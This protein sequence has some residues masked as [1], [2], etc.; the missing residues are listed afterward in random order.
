MHDIMTENLKNA[1]EAERFIAIGEVGLDF[2]WTREN[3]KE[4]LQA[5]ARQVEW[6]IETRTL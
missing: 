6:S 4:Q 5:F 3:E 1:P 2:Y